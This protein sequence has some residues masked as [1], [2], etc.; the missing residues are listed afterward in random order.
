MAEESLAGTRAGPAT[1]AGHCEP[2]S[3]SGDVTKRSVTA[4]CGPSSPR[5]IQP[6]RGYLAQWVNALA[7]LQR[8][9]RR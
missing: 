7:A 6:E 9:A 8:P 1:V 5:R 3:H 2:G 4:S